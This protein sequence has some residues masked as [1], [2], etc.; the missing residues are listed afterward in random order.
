MSKNRQRR[1][2]ISQPT[3]DGALERERAHKR[4]RRD[5]AIREAEVERA[6]GGVY[7]VRE[8]PVLEAAAQAVAD[9]RSSLGG[10]RL[11]RPERR[12]HVAHIATVWHGPIM[13]RADEI[14]RGVRVEPG[15]DA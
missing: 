12:E 10:R 9:A 3:F 2:A 5:N 14:L 15:G 7:A 1:T 6:R 4:R 13:E 8:D 11:K